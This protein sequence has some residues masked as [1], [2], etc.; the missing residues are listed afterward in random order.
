MLCIVGESGFFIKSTMAATAGAT[1]VSYDT[2][3][4]NYGLLSGSPPFTSVQTSSALSGAYWVH[5][6]L[7]SAI[8]TS[9]T[10]SWGTNTFVVGLSRAAFD[11]TSAG[12]LLSS[13]TTNPISTAI[14]QGTPTGTKTYDTSLIAF[15]TAAIA[16]IAN[17]MPVTDTFPQS[18][19]ITVP[20]PSSGS[21]PVPIFVSLT[22]AAVSGS[23]H[24][25]QLVLNSQVI[26]QN[27]FDRTDSS[28]DTITS[29]TIISVLAGT[30]TFSV[31]L[32]SGSTSC[33]ATN[34]PCSFSYFS[35]APNDARFTTVYWSAYRS[36][37]LLAPAST[38]ATVGF[39]IVSI[40]GQTG[41]WDGQNNAVVASV[42]GAYYININ[43]ATQPNMNLD[44]RIFVNGI[45]A[46]IGLSSFQSSGVVSKSRAAIV[47]LNQGDRVTVVAAS[48]TGLYGDTNWPSSSFSGFLLYARQ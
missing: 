15:S 20:P 11:M 25:V 27:R 35:Y 4:N 39:D 18:F 19:S 21:G 28:S 7:A 2:A 36:S 30:L 12:A 24:V 31:Q 23:S 33:S 14:N 41:L 48:S 5:Q 42:T 26:L 6:T 44:V 9:V 16:G 40:V 38:Q 46:S 47:M 1:T 3:V 17:T 29:A 37:P 43:A 45:D 34:S 10:S 8:S 13:S 32:V 22:T